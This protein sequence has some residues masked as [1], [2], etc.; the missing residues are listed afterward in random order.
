[1][2]QKQVTGRLELIVGPDDKLYKV[3][4]KS[5]PGTVQTVEI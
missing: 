4:I 2:L 5:F 3:V 1:M